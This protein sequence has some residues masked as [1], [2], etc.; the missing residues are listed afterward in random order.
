MSATKTVLVVQLRLSDKHSSELSRQARAVNFVWNY[1]NETQKKA[2]RSNRKWLSAFDLMKLTSGSS[3]ELGLHAHTI[4]R[5]CRTYA[6]ARSLQKRPW[7]RWRGQ[8][9]LGWIPF[10][11]GHVTISAERL[12]KFR[13]ISYK[14]MHWRDVLV[15]GSKIG[16][17]SFNSDAR[18]RWYVNLTIEVKCADSR[19]A[20]AVGVDLGLKSL[21]TLSSG[22]TIE[23]P[24]FYRRCEQALAVAQRARKTKRARN[25]HAK[26]RNRRK[27]FLHKAANAIVQEYGTII[28][29]NM[30]PSGLAKTTMAKSVNDAGLAG[31]KKMLSYKAIMHG[32]RFLEVSEAYSTQ[33]CSVCGGLPLSRPRGIAGLRIREW[34]CDDCGAVHDRDVNAAQNILRVGLDALAAGAL[35]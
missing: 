23:P 11:T 26:A 14:A 5:V 7:L 31:F 25:I 28:V 12:I 17:G 21:A 1:C 15:P 18:G 29:G 8:K 6:D 9:S 20:P 10:N 34:R 2:A 16:V 13:G 24:R 19:F 22:Q 32:G 33:T 3:R 27:D 4:Q 35:A 30:N